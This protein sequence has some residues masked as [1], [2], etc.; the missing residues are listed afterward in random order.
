MCS[1]GLRQ[2]S[3]SELNVVCL[4]ALRIAMRIHM[5]PYEIDDFE[6]IFDAAR[7]ELIPRFES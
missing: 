3:E 6:N 5:G 2:A 4:S 7:T 1:A